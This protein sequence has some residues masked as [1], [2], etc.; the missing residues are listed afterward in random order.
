MKNITKLLF[1]FLFLASI[2][3]FSQTYKKNDKVE[4]EYSGSWYPGY[5]METKDNQYK[6]HYD[7][8]DSSYDEWVT[9][10]RLKTIGGNPTTKDEEIKPVEQK[11][12]DVVPVK[13]ETEVI[14]SVST[15]AQSEIVVTYKS[16]PLIPVVGTPI[17]ITEFVC[18]N[19]EKELTSY[20][21]LADVIVPDDAIL[22]Y[23]KFEF[24]IYRIGCVQERNTPKGTPIGT[25]AY[26]GG[27][28]LTKE[29]VKPD[30]SGKKT[31]VHI[32]IYSAVNNQIKSMDP[33][34]VFCADT[35]SETYLY[36]TIVGYKQ[37]ST[38]QVWHENEGA[39][40]TEPVYSDR[41][42]IILGKSNALLIK[43]DVAT[44]KKKIKK[45]LW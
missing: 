15:S 22:K 4:I 21:D 11:K 5:I 17:V 33:K 13:K 14:S 43:P 9:T 29:N 34:R 6:I 28:W 30:A 7:A 25:P 23:D 45:G 1:L 24:Q 3:G 2:Q 27:D 31:T 10:S 37:I 35:C 41:G 38:K 44:T 16:T 42:E 8:Y 12:K 20:P 18:E 32:N 19:I 26:I 39:W 40:Y 36:I